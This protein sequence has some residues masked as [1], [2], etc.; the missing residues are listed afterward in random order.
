MTEVV[1]LTIFFQQYLFY[2]SAK[3]PDENKKSKEDEQT[4]VKLNSDLADHHRSQAKRQLAQTSH[5][6]CHA[7]NIL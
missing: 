2:V 7:I 5:N 1:S 6:E 3:K 4:L